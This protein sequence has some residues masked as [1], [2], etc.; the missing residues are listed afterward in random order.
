MEKVCILGMGYIGMPTA[1]MLANNGYEVIGVEIDSKII[2][3]LNS[4]KL[5]IDEP[6]LEEIF[7]KAYKD[8]K[9]KVLAKSEKSDVYIIAVQTPL[10]NQK[11]ADLSHV[12]SATNMIKD[13]ISNGCL[14]ILESTSPPGTT[15]NIVGDI[16]YRS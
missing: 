6:D 9:I 12:T 10:N 11:K 4:G 14:V 1:C 13:Y 2:N 8:K 3:K 5:H 7:L 15:R 16:I